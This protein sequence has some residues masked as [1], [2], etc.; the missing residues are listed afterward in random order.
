MSEGF[1]SRWSKRKIDERAGKPLPEPDTQRQAAP[2]LDAMANFS[3]GTASSNAVVNSDADRLGGRN[4]DL[5]PVV[6]SQSAPTQPAPTETPAAELPTLADVQDLTPESDFK[7]F[8][9]R[10]VAADVKNAA[11]KK[12]FADP[13]FNVM[14]RLDTYIDDYSLP[15]P[16]PAA[17]LRKMVSAKFLNLFDDEEEPKV[18]GGDDRTELD[19]NITRPRDD[20]DT[21]PRA[22]VAQSLPTPESTPKNDNLDLRLQSDHAP[23]VQTARRGAE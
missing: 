7:P 23:A 5:A 17:M 8:M 13:H 20:P 9:A 1:L 11:M 12:L 18:G 3:G 4:I 19:A 16:I 21:A 15:D 14:D 2:R 10:G 6:A 22:D